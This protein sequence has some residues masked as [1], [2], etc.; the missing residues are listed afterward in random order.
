MSEKFFQAIK[1]GD[2]DSVVAMLGSDSG[3]LNARDQNGLDAYTTARYHGKN[4]IAKFLLEKGVQLDVFAASLA[5]D[6]ERVLTLID[7]NP[8]L[9]GAYSQD[10]WTPLHLACFFGQPALTEALIAR[11][12]DLT[13]RSRNPLKNTPLHA[14]VAGRNVPAVRALIERGAD[15]NARQEGGWTPMHSA[16]QNGDTEMLQLLIAA[17][18]N[19]TV[20]AD[21]QQTPLDLALGKGHQATVDLLEAYA[22]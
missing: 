3:L 5:G 2:T 21:N 14:A 10:G 16:A 22:A 17:G 9:I 7:Q 4:D 11:G 13:A 20:R 15:V 12:A 1:S 18:A 8:E 6:K 19:V